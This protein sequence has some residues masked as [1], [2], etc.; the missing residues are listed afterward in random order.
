[1]RKCAALGA[2]RPT[3]S[4]M[5]STESS[6]QLLPINSQR[7]LDPLIFNVESE[8]HQAWLKQWSVALSVILDHYIKP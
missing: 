2:Q 6:V 4:P 8:E 7:L 3:P 5:V 1:M